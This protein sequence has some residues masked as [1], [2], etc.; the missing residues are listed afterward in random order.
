ML[1]DVR[2]SP[3]Y[4]GGSEIMPGLACTTL[5]LMWGGRE[6]KRERSCTGSVESRV[7]LTP[8]VS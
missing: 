6:V 4:C 8:A 5:S 1:N 3:W 2:L 7:T